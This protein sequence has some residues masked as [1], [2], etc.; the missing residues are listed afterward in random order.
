MRRFA[1]T[2]VF[3]GDYEN[4]APTKRLT[5]ISEA[6]AGPNAIDMFF[7]AQSSV[8]I[9]T[10]AR[11]SL[12]SVASWVSSYIA[13]CD[14]IRISYPPPPTSSV[15]KWSGIFPAGRTFLVYVNRLMEACI[16]PWASPGVE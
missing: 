1:A 7:N 8:N 16:P 15:R 14:T 6:N 3:G 9:S 12:P 4:T 5:I 13:F 2:P 10:Q 11:P